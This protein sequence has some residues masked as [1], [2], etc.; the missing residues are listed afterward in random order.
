M[1]GHVRSLKEK[2]SV[3]NMIP[4]MFSM[5]TSILK[6]EMTNCVVCSCLQK[7]KIGI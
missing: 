3:F 5:I 1:R 7:M 6:L 2:E 4:Y